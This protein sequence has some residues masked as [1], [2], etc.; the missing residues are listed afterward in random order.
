VPW[1]RMPAGA[2][3]YAILVLFLLVTVVPFFW[4]WSSALR[5]SREIFMDPFSLPSRL[6]FTNLVKAWTVGRFRG[7]FL[8]TLIITV[9]TVAGVV[10]LS[11]LAGYALG[12]LRLAYGK[13]LLYLFL[14]GLMVPFQSIMIPLYYIL[15]D[16]RILGTYW[17]MILPAVT[18]GLPFGVFLMQAF[19]RGLPGELA[20]AAR[21]DGCGELRCFRSVMLPLAGPAVSSLVVF[22]FMWTWNAFLMPLVYLQ[23]ENLR[24]LA[25]GLMFFQ[26]RYTQD[27]GLIAGGVAIVTIPIILVYIML[28]RQFVRGLTA[29]AL[30]G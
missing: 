3:K 17:G 5:S 12:R 21:V 29:G 28:Q 15:R 6:D 2:A 23:R 18:L 22:Q 11:C 24:P 9:P 20:D 26:G 1:R 30:K 14:L 7:Y 25:L 13:P 16:I 19:F 4:M 10:A 27:Y 8:N